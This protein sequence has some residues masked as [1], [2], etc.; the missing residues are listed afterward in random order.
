MAFIGDARSMHGGLHYDVSTF[1]PIPSGGTVARAKR[2]D[3]AEARRRYRASLSEELEPLDSEDELEPDASPSR[4][5]AAP[6]RARSAPAASG[7]PPRPSLIGAFRNSFRP[8]DLRSDLQALPRLLIDKSVFLPVLLTV[9]ATI[10]FI[11]APTQI[12]TVLLF[13]YF[14]FTPPLAAIFLAGFMAPRASYLTGAIA[15]LA[16]A[17]GFAVWILSSIGQP[18]QGTVVTEAFA[19]ESIGVGLVTSTISGIFFGAAAGWYRR[20]LALANPSRAARAAG[21]PSDKNR[22]RSDSRPLLARRR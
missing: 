14:V 13:Q 4:A 12:V 10:G 22:K 17:I 6:A 20:F 8:F 3:R 1:T 9:A 2:T 11:A 21:R 15:G 18:I 16:G 5:S 7:L 19:R